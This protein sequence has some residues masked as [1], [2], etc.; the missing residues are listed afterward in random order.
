MHAEYMVNV[1]DTARLHVSALINPSIKSERIF[2]YAQ[3]YNWNSILEVLRK[4]RPE[5]KFPED[6]SDNS[7]DLSTIAGIPRAEA[8]LREDW[9]QSGFVGLEESLKQNIAHL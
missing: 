7:K 6:L 5:H 3:P 8:I 9:G 4:L 1:Q 2:A